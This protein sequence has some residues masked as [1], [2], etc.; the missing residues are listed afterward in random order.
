MITA[1]TLRATLKEIYG[2]E[3]K[4]IV[5]I[6]NNWFIP[7]V[8]PLEKTGSWIGYRILSKEPQARGIDY[9]DV[10]SKAVKVR[11]R[12]SFVG[13]QAEEFADQTILWEDRKDVTKVFE[14]TMNAQINYVDRTS[15]SYPIRN[16]GFNDELCWVVDFTAQTFYETK[17][18]RVPGKW[19]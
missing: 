6:S 2:V 19:H 5:P 18:K 1:E 3:D 13:P 12:I 17:I 7:S 10:F 8:N 11:F 14:D 16:G 15:F 9:G 4:Y